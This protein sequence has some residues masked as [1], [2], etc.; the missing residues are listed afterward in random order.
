MQ[1]FELV[2]VS[3]DSTTK[4]SPEGEYVL[5]SDATAETA[6]LRALL[7]EAR[8]IVVGS[9]IPTGGHLGDIFR[10]LRER[11]DAWLA[12]LAETEGVK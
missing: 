1:R 12:A 8:G 6:K 7:A 5:Y 11:R 4:E 9:P 2:H 10:S 3:Y